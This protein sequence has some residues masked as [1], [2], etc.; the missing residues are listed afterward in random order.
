MSECKALTGEKLRNAI[1]L[2]IAAIFL[3]A[4]L[5]TASAGITFCYPAGA[6]NYD[7]YTY[8]SGYQVYSY[9]TGA[10]YTFANTKNIEVQCIQAL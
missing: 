7:A 10:Y 9:N 5:G 2:A 3:I 1:V 6:H 8:G 4:A